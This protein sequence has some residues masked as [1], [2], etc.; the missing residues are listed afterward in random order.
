[1]IINKRKTYG[2]ILKDL[3]DWETANMYCGH[4]G[5]KISEDSNFCVFCGQPTELQKPQNELAEFVRKARAGDKDAFG[6]LYNNTYNQAFYTV[7]SMIKDDDAVNDILQDSYVKAFLHMD[8]FKG[9]DKFLPWI[10]QIAANTARD[11]LKKK[12]PMLFTD[13]NDDDDMVFEEQIE[14]EREENIPEKLIEHKE[15]IRLIGEIVDSLPD[16]QRAVIGMYYYEKKS[17]SDIASAMGASQSAIKSRL[18][19]GRD[20]IKAKVEEL[21]S[22]GTNLYGLAPFT[23]WLLLI[24]NMKGFT[25]ELIPDANILHNVIES[26]DGISHNPTKTGH[27]GDTG[28]GNVKVPGVGAAAT[29]GCV[30]AAKVILI[31]LIST[32]AIGGGIFGISKVIGGSSAGKEVVEDTIDT[33]SLSDKVESTMEETEAKESTEA[34]SSTEAAESI[35]PNDEALEQY[36]IVVEQASTYKFDDDYDFSPTG[37]YQYALVKMKSDDPVQ[38]LLLAQEVSNGDSYVRLFKY[39]TDTKVMHQPYKPYI[40]VN[41]SSG[42]TSVNVSLNKMANGDGLRIFGVSRGRGDVLIQKV[43]LEGDNLDIEDVYT[44]KLGDDIPAELD[45]LEIEWHN[46]SD[47]SVFGTQSNN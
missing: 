26:I 17:V 27:I 3:F 44:G 8:S 46:S 18:K 5:K 41:F 10:K 21:K 28:K 31:A 39:D 2:C 1:M 23:F 32:T 16:D 7:K 40:V 15:T 25:T 38:T 14:D 20:K 35:S 43:T 6:V 9:D 29:T 42:R 4:C 36:K 47:L 19:Y 22:K 11:W 34:I 24:R 13:L 33:N 30:G 37:N 45:G 12:K